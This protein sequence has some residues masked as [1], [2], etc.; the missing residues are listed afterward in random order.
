MEKPLH[1]LLSSIITIERRKELPIYLQIVDQLAAAIKRK[2]IPQNTK[3]PGTRRLS[4]LLNVHRSTIVAAYEELCQLGYLKVVANKGTFV[5]PISDL[6]TEKIKNKLFDLHLSYPKSTGYKFNK[7][8]VLDNPFETNVCDLKFTDG[9]PDLRLT[10]IDVLSNAYSANLKRVGNRRKMGDPY[11]SG[12]SYFREK[13][14]NYLN[15]SRGLHISHRN[16][17]I[18]RGIQ[19]G[20]YVVCQTLLNSEDV[21]LVGTPSYFSAN[22]VFQQSGAKVCQIAMDDEGI[23]IEELERYCKSSEVR[24]LYLTPHFHYPT[25]VTLSAQRRSEVLN[26]ASKY[27]FI[28]I[29]D[30]YDF[31]F[32][33]GQKTILPMASADSEGMVIYI[34]NIGRSLAPGFRTGFVV[35]PENL[36]DELRKRMSI[37]DRQGDVLMEQALG[38]LIEEGQLDRYI[39]RSLKTY[40]DRRDYLAEVLHTDFI[41]FVEF[42]TPSGGLA[43][44]TRWRSDINLL[45]VSK[46]C[47]S[48]GLFIPKVLLYQ[49]EK[50]HAMRIGFGHL[51]TREMCEALE[52]LHESLGC[53]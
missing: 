5:I 45:K 47:V 33:Y 4:E 6:Q 31:D 28:V 41:N 49:N 40:K 44:W 48:K 32:N 8:N 12:S 1:L 13:L 50:I 26:L 25:T 37:V 35:A 30:D 39:K 22:M 20:L 19:M 3:L 53:M 23:I 16:L 9:T 36:I 27:G 21:V 29:E 14:A 10:Q 42:V 46:A 34:G 7:T 52:I 38:E 17:L 51:E 43:I 15:L 2:I 18:S 11:L 24:M